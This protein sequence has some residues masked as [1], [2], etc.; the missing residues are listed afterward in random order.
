MKYLVMEIDKDK[1]LVLSSD[2][3]FIKV[4]NFNYEIGQQLDQISQINFYH[5]TKAHI[6]KAAFILTC[7]SLFFFSYYYYNYLNIYSSIFFSINPKI[8]MDLNAKGDVIKL[9][10]LNDEAKELLVNY[11]YKNKDKYL[12]S[13]EL[14]ELFKDNNYFINNKTI[15]IIIESNDQNLK[16]EYELTFLKQLNSYINPEEIT[17]EITLPQLELISVKQ[18]LQISI[19][20]ANLTNYEIIHQNLKFE[21][22]LAFYQISLTDINYQYDFTINAQNGTIIK[23]S[24]QSLNKESETSFSLEQAL[25]LIYDHCQLESKDLYFTKN[26]Y[27]NEIYQISFDHQNYHYDYQISALE[28]KIIS[29]EKKIINQI[30]SK[31]ALSIA[32]DHAKCTKD[33]IE[34][35]KIELHEE[36]ENYYYEIQFEKEDNEYE[37]FINA[38]N[39][40]I[41]KFED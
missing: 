20:Q 29:F 35:L 15:T 30:S 27:E 23:V 36:N 2:G 33:E 12:I 1:A 6:T 34:E 9:V 8:R 37:Y 38:L 4:K 5:L 16:K 39:K 21:N 10:G 19:D 40:E 14:V 41:I 25:Q 11:N 22:D 18:A 26:D 32:L 31:E 13:Q 24:K 3:N 28:K 7:L 17:I